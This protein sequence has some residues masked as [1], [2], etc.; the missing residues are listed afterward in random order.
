MATSTHLKA[1]RIPC[2]DSLVEL[3]EIPLI[4]VGQGGISE[5]ECRGI[6][7]ELEHIPN[8]KLLDAPRTF[9]WDHRSLFIRQ[10]YQTEG[11]E[12]WWVDYMIYMSL[13]SGV[14]LPPNARIRSVMQ[15]PNREGHMA[16]MEEIELY[17]DA[18]V[19]KMNSKSPGS[20]EPKRAAYTDMDEVFISSLKGGSLAPFIMGELLL[21]PAKSG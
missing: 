17:G 15:D 10:S 21:S 6:E 8:M 5:R 14:G 3:M 9:S 11:F 2:D 12:P 18:F 20:G 16:G 19:F 13:D 7:K 4:E 1:V